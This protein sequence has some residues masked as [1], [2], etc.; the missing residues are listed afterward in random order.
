MIFM[1]LMPERSHHPMSHTLTHR[2]I[3]RIGATLT[4]LL[5]AALI[6]P[7]FAAPPAG[8]G[9][10]RDPAA[11]D[12]AYTLKGDYSN[13]SGTSSTSFISSYGSAY[14]YAT[15]LFGSSSVTDNTKTLR[16]F[17]YGDN[18]VG[19]EGEGHGNGVNGIGIGPGGV[20]VNGMHDDIHGTAAG[21][22]AGTHSI[23]DGATAV[24]GVIDP[25]GDPGLNSVGVIG[26]NT[27]TSSK[28]IG[29][30]GTQYGTGWG[31]YGAVSGAGR[32]VFGESAGV[33]VY[34][35][36]TGT[37][38]NVRGVYGFSSEGQ[39]VYGASTVAGSQ[40]VR[41][42]NVSG[43]GVYG[44]SMYGT[45]GNFESSQGDGLW[46]STDDATAYALVTGGRG[47]N[48]DTYIGGDLH[49]TGACCALV[50]TDAGARQMYAGEVTRQIFS[51]EGTATLANGRAVITID[52]LFAQAA[53]LNADYQ[54]F[55]TPH[56]ADTA[57]LAAVNLTPTGFEVRELNKGQG[58]FKFS[59]R[60]D[61]VRKGYEQVRM[62]PAPAAPTAPD[63]PP[64]PP[65]PPTT[66]AAASR[67]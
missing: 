61:A 21:V 13:T 16:S 33:G 41:G 48:G 20:G 28:G 10:Q 59:W 5:L 29:V 2:H 67:H 66:S 4:A 58:S 52:S 42:H 47:S 6:H 43:T 40:G 53:N 32:G 1:S 24:K 62:A 38:S 55:L 14:G 27:S 9:P 36:S 8:D 3:R 23:D 26:I 19:V 63:V 64:A 39:G 37:G 49:V 44:S 56:S 51:D 54:V 12:A 22:Q 60:I 65:D 35:R 46:A 31:V 25:Y 15:W 57:G 18:C 11:P 30:W 34:G 50:A 17:C 7:T 45:G